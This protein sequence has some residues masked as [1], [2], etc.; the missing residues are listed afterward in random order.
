MDCLP[1][2][3]SD[4]FIFVSKSLEE[5]SDEQIERLKQ[6]WGAARAF[7]AGPAVLGRD[8]VGLFP[9]ERLLVSTLRGE[10]SG[11]GFPPIGSLPF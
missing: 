10:D 7:P 11:G 5:R 6:F 1:I 9:P 8:A 3:P 4:S 2:I